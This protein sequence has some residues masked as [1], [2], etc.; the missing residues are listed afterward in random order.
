MDAKTLEALNGSIEK[1]RKIV[2]GTG[3]DLAANN[4]P[5]CSLFNSSTAQGLKQD[6][7]LA[8]LGCPVFD[9]TGRRFCMGTPYIEWVKMVHSTMSR[10]R[11]VRNEQD[12]AIAQREVD[13][14]KSL[15]PQESPQS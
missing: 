13:F 6:L 4:C 14:L 2:D 1:W 12:R 8:C 15:L 9:N 5:L 10:G 7:E 11:Q 3:V